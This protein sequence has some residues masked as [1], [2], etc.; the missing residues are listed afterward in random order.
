MKNHNCGTCLVRIEFIDILKNVENIVMKNADS[1][2]KST[3]PLA[4]S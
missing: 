3:L 1:I 4:Q 2:F